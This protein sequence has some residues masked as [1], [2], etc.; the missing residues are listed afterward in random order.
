[1]RNFKVYSL[2]TF[3]FFCGKEVTDE[4][5]CQMVMEQVSRETI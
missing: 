4:K 3:L 2:T 1:M 5:T